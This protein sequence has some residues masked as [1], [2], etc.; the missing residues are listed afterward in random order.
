MKDLLPSA[1]SPLI[2]KS[3]F[4]DGLF[5]I[6]LNVDASDI[7]FMTSAVKDLPMN[8]TICLTAAGRSYQREK[9]RKRGIE[10]LIALTLMS[11]D[12]AI[13]NVDFD[14]KRSNRY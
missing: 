12:P 1:A 7:F 13:L 3:G 9:R 10:S 5:F 14:P 11:V 6:A 8:S 2:K 4:A